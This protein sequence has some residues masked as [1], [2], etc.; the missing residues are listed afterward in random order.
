V[1]SLRRSSRRV[2]SGEIGDD[3]TRFA[4]AKALKA[5]AGTAPIALGQVRGRGVSRLIRDSSGVV[6]R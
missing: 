2:L 6:R 3:R 1:I 5:F 4:D